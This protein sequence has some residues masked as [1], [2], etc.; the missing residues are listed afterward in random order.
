MTLN[1]SLLRA[2]AWT[3]AL[4]LS[5]CVPAIAAPSERI[6]ENAGEWSDVLINESN[7][8]IS[9]NQDGFTIRITPEPN[10][11]FLYVT[12]VLQQS[13]GIDGLFQIG[14]FSLPIKYLSAGG[15]MPTF[16]AI[17]PA[18]E[19]SDFVHAFTSLKTALVR[20]GSTDYTISLTGTSAAIDGLNFYAHEHRLDLPKPFSDTTTTSSD[21]TAQSPP[22]SPI[23]PEGEK[24]DTEATNPTPEG[25]C[26]DNFHSCK[27]NEDL[28]NNYSGFRDARA[29]CK[30]KA[31]DAAEYG[32]PKWPGLWGGGAFGSFRIGTDAPRTGIVT[33]MEPNAQFQNAYGAMVHST[34]TCVYDLNQHAIKDIEVTPH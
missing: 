18:D 13:I 19:T 3:S 12:V 33:L 14:S 7:L 24:D 16:G 10:K 5:L 11:H 4:S 22:S 8:C 32:T 2:F 26:K 21:Q 28:V 34:V 27:D 30:I 29:D 25:S 6:I 1:F 17:I 23:S 9:S 15:P 31:D 20:I